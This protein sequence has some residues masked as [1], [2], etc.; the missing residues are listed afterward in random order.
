MTSKHRNIITSNYCSTL[1]NFYKN[2][3]NNNIHA[4]NRLFRQR[5][6]I[7]I[8]LLVT[9]NYKNPHDN[10]LLGWSHWRSLQFYQCSLPISKGDSCLSFSNYQQK[11]STSTILCSSW[12]W[13]LLNNNNNIIFNCVF[14]QHTKKNLYRFQNF[15]LSQKKKN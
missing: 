12:R 10:L 7:Y 11:N 13:I 15:I 6:L 4:N 9:D 1:S 14:S 3:S 5:L 2:N 8:L